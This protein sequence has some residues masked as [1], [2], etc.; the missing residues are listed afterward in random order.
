MARAAIV[1]HYTIK[2][3]EWI[4]S[5]RV[6]IQIRY[7]GNS[8]SS[9]GSAGKKLVESRSHRAKSNPSRLVAGKYEKKEIE[10]KSIWKKAWLDDPCTWTY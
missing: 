3:S 1:K 9:S 4:W 5:D 7:Q 2:N 8:S 10:G 6:R